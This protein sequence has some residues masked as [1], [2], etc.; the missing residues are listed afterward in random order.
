M[1]NS[2]QQTTSHKRL[3][4]IS[5]TAELYLFG[6]KVTYFFLILYLLGYI[7]CFLLAHYTLSVIKKSAMPEHHS[8]YTVRSQVREQLFFLIE[9]NQS[10]FFRFSHLHI[11]A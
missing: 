10:V 1:S 8:R 4:H 7:N 3:H 5:P 9:S 11:I 6:Y 2:S